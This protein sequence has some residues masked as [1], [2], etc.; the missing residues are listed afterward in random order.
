MLAMHPILEPDVIELINNNRFSGPLEGYVMTDGPTYLGSALFTVENGITNV[1][2]S[3]VAETQ[4]LDGI[5]RACIA[6]G[7]N[8]GA[9]HFTVN[10]AQPELDTW[11]K[12]FCTNQPIPAPVSHLFTFC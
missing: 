9:K 11:W 8:R 7:D 4:N 12:V 6:S 10:H 1:L 5:I 2:A 3:D